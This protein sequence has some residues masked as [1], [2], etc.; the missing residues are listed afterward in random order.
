VK[1]LRALIGLALLLALGASAS[2]AA[3]GPAPP[4]EV[5]VMRRGEAWTAELRFHRQAKAW[6]FARSPVTA[7]GEKPWRPLSW[8][9]LTPGVRLERRGHYDVLVAANAGPVPGV[10]RV[11]FVP[12]WRDVLG[13]YVPALRFTDGSVALFSEQFALLPFASAAA[14]G[15]LPDDLN[16]AGVPESA[17][18]VT[19][20]DAAG[21]V[22]V[23]GRRVANAVTEG[24]EGTYVLFGPAR[25]IVTDSITAVIDPKLP[26]WLG[27]ALSRA[28]PQILAGYA[29]AFGPAPGA[30]P[31]LLVSW[32]GPTAGR[33]S[34]TGSTLP[35]LVVMNFEGVG[36]LKEDARARG[37]NL[38]F[39][40]HES[41]HFWL[42]QAVRY[43]TAYESWITEGGA[44]LLA[45][46]TVAAVDPDYDAR[47]ELQREVDDCIKLSAGRGVASALSRNEYR[48]YYACGAVFGL[49]A[50]AASRRPFPD[51]V[52][53]LLE[54]NRADGIVTRAEWLAALDRVSKD[55][56]LSAGI[57]RMLDKGAEDP[58]A[59]IAALF[60]R[61]GVAF[62]PAADGTPML[63]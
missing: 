36:L 16:V 28:T 10:V 50:E 18:R 29:R 32:T 41:A 55:R 48:A 7:E 3:A 6:L 37:L 33:T 8:T 9:V 5:A 24:G 40:A 34:M 62:T 35:A 15:R 30:K 53:G 59:A 19:Y 27:A 2:A 57:G 25:P 63:R 44:D 52:R 13:S 45:I 42:G 4:A 1:P 12:F 14:V 17:T 23:A 21:P 49:V 56:T 43:D 58:K 11:R 61:A 54:A 47:A 46:R 31:T 26:A 51:F 38:W 22:L 39:I 60:T 20:R